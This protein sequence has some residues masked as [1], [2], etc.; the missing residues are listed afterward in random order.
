MY[1]V[2]MLG[3]NAVKMQLQEKE[4]VMIPVLQEIRLVKAM[5]FDK[6]APA[7]QQLKQEVEAILK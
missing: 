7:I 6:F 3:F 1:E 2:D 5:T 4:F